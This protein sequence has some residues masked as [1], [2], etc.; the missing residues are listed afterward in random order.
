MADCLGENRMKRLR[1]K[2]EVALFNASRRIGA[3]SLEAAIILIELS[4][5]KKRIESWHTVMSRRSPCATPLIRKPHD[6]KIEDP[7]FTLHSQISSKQMSHLFR[8][9]T[10]NQTAPR[11]GGGISCYG[12]YPGRGMFIIRGDE[13]TK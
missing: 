11:S 1:I 7:R 2:I 8:V 3:L 13:R 4:S 5:L 6:P 9:A 10:M 12:L